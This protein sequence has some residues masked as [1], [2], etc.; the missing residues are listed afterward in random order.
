MENTNQQPQTATESIGV[1][2]LLVDHEDIVF[3][4]GDN[5]QTRDAKSA[6]Q[7]VNEMSAELS[8]VHW[9]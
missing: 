8:G 7:Q 3:Q 1:Q 2:E 4:I 9:R 6:S 5:K